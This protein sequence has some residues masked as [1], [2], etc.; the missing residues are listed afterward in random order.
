MWERDSITQIPHPLR[1]Y[2]TSRVLYSTGIERRSPF[3]TR[4][5]RKKKTADLTER[6]NCRPVASRADQANPLASHSRLRRPGPDARRKAAMRRRRRDLGPRPS[7]TPA[8][9][10]AAAPGSQSA[11]SGRDRLAAG[12]PRR[13][14]VRASRGTRGA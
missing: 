5:T 14:R 7:T 1:V 3:G 13:C 4:E 6:D 10:T 11:R 9:P 2:A 12:V 8:D